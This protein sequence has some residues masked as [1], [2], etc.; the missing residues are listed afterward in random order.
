MSRIHHSPLTGYIDLDKIARISD[1]RFAYEGS[2]IGYWV[3]CQ[4]DIQLRD[5]PIRFSRSMLPDEE[6]MVD[7]ERLK[8]ARS[9]N[10][11]GYRL[12]LIDGALTNPANEKLEPGEYLCVQRVQQQIDELVAV[13]KGES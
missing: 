2:G 5:E 6:T 1:A 8:E 12:V 7:V 13:W 9:Y 11:F 10:D 4:I 3:S